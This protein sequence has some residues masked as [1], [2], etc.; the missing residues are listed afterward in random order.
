MSKKTSVQNERDADFQ[1]II[2]SRELRKKAE[3]L[4]EN[5]R[6]I[7]ERAEVIIARSIAQKR[8]LVVPS[9]GDGGC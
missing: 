4:L 2:Q 7:R 5:A 3:E 1:V 6:R 8:T 9:L